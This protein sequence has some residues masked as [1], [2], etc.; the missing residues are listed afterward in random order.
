MAQR[1]IAAEDAFQKATQIVSTEVSIPTSVR[2]NAKYDGMDLHR[3]LIALSVGNSFAESGM[4]RLALECEGRVPSGSWVRDTAG[5][6]PERE[7]REKLEGA[8]AS[9]VG[10]VRSFRLFTTP[11]MCAADLHEIPRYDRDS[12]G[13]YLRRSKKERGTNTF[14]G[15]AT[16]QCVEE[17]MRAQLACEHIGLFD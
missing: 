12:D 11:V 13:G 7:M 5:R 3:S 2:Y 16:L 6:V 14:E 1:Y 17:G 10:Q 15:Y 8:L 9:T 4:E